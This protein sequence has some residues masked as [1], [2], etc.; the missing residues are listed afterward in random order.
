MLAVYGDAPLPSGDKRPVRLFPIHD[1]VFGAHCPAL[2]ALPPSQPRTAP[3]RATL[4]VVPLRLLSPDTF[5]LL[6]GYLYT[7]SLAALA[8]LCD[9]DLL[10]LAAHAHRIRGLRSNA[11]ELGVVDERLCGAVEETWVHT[12]SA[13]QAC[14]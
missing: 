14:S 13:M 5:A 6:H 2:P 1:L 9:A 8:P 3:P 10:Q 4:P 7:Q 11:C 12:L